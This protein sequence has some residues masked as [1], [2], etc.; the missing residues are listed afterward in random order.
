VAAVASPALGRLADLTLIAI[1]V[2][3]EFVFIAIALPGLVFTILK[4]LIG[5]ARPSALGPFH[6]VPFS[7]RPDLASLPSGHSTAAFAAAIAI[8][9]LV[10]RARPALWI[11]AGVIAL[12]RVVIAAHYPSDVIAGAVGGAFGA[13]L[14]RN[15]FASR[16]L[17]FTAAPDGKIR[18]RPGPSLRRIRSIIARAR[19]GR[20]CTGHPSVACCTEDVPPGQQRDG[21]GHHQ[22]GGEDARHKA[23]HD[24]REAS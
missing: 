14:V 17:V 11:Y 10:P 18:Y 5:R 20:A 13:I 4:R 23:G 22:P 12:S 16:G 8:G 1:M 2:R 21:P 9:A 6:Y 24:G 3:L 19:H 7:W 15:W